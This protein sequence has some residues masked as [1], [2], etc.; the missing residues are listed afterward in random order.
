MVFWVSCEAGTYM[1]TLCVHLGLLLGTGGHMQELRRVRSGIMGEKDNMVT[2]HDVLD[3]QVGGEGGAA[4]CSLLGLGAVLTQAV[5][6]RYVCIEKHGLQRIP[7]RREHALG[8]SLGGPA[9]V[10]AVGCGL[11]ATV[12]C[13][14]PL[15]LVLP[16]PAPAAAVALRQLQ[17]RVLPAARSD[18]AGG[19]ADQLQARGGQGLRHQ[20]HL[21]RCQAHD[22]GALAL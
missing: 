3:A 22:P 9:G 11:C 20:R 10:L 5:T 19:A 12:G 6:L 8:C 16:F 15:R 1:R 7:P 18:A 17:G 21:L 14:L 2:M 13:A 4:I